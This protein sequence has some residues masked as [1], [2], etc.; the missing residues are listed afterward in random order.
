MSLK[1]RNFATLSSTC[2]G[3]AGHPGTVY[4]LTFLLKH[5]EACINAKYTSDQASRA[6]CNEV[7][8]D[9]FFFPSDFCSVFD[10]CMHGFVFVSLGKAIMNPTW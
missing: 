5:C 7:E 10:I 9:A 3:F 8:C 4:N 1:M 6:L 2:S